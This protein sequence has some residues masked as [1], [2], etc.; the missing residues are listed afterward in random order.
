MQES[1]VDNAKEKAKPEKRFK[2]QLLLVAQKKFSTFGSVCKLP[3]A[4]SIHPLVAI[5]SNP[6]IQ[7]K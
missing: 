4:N 6:H 5:L 3:Q 2:I 1:E 7:T